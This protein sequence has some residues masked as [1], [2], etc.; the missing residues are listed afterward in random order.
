M[1]NLVQLEVDA[2]N[3]AGARERFQNLIAHIVRFKH[4]KS[5]EILAGRGDWGIDVLHG[6]LTT[7]SCLVWQAKYFIRGV[8]AHERNDIEESF[9]QLIEKSAEKGFTVN[10]WTLCIPCLLTTDSIVWWETWKKQIDNQF[11]ITI[12]L[13]Q[14]TDIEEFFMAPETRFIMRAF[15]L[16]ERPYEKMGE[17]HIVTLSNEEAVGY[18]GSLFIKKLIAAGIIETMAARHQFFN[19]EIMHRE[20]I[21]KG[22]PEEIDELNRLEKKI[23]SMWEFRFNRALKSNDPETETMKVCFDLQKAIEKLDKGTLD[24]PVTLASLVHKLGVMHQLANVCRVGWTPNFHE[25]DIG[26]ST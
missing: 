17:R 26:G 7:G 14:L 24:A 25:L 23:W 9:Q 18:D 1:R 8:N 22:D 3:I 2:T 21:D 15:N 13:M 19:A 16:D 5:M 12:D 20:I 10:G 6:T 11:K 4:K